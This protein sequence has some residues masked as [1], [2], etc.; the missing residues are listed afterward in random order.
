M[1]TALGG[2]RV[3]PEIGII[4]SPALGHKFPLR[5]TRQP[6]TNP[7]RKLLGVYPAHVIDRV[8]EAV[9]FR[10][11]KMNL[12]LKRR[13]NKRAAEREHHFERSRAAVLDLERSDLIDRNEVLALLG[14]IDQREMLWRSEQAPSAEF[15]ALQRRLQDGLIDQ[16]RYD[17]LEGELTDPGGLAKP[18]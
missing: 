1:H 17:S 2:R 9:A 14:Q 5:L 10:L 4:L 11:R 12:H 8:V 15:S 16:E 13:Q 6:R 18:D 3:A 7:G